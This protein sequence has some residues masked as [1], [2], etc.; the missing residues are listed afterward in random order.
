MARTAVAPTN[1]NRVERL[2]EVSRT[3]K[4]QNGVNFGRSTRSSQ[5]EQTAACDGLDA[6][7]GDAAIGQ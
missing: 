1:G 4:A 3:Q 7:A 2:S 5:D 6:L